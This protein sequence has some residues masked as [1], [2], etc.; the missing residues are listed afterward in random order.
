MALLTTDRTFRNQTLPNFRYDIF[1]PFSPRWSYIQTIKGAH[2]L[3]L[4]LVES[5]IMFFSI[6]NSFHISWQ[7]RATWRRIGETEWVNNVRDIKTWANF[8]LNTSP[9]SYRFCLGDIPFWLLSPGYVLSIHFR[10]NL[11]Y[12]AK[13][14]KWQ[15]IQKN[16]IKLIMFYLQIVFC[17][18]TPFLLRDI[19]VNT[20]WYCIDVSVIRNI[21]FC[22]FTRNIKYVT[23]FLLPKRGR[24]VSTGDRRTLGKMTL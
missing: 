21:M 19:Q 1:P 7:Y 3:R 10:T 5:M 13:G 15:I 12:L 9:H 23:C 14:S 20:S 8:I 17:A 11:P 6:N 16:Y 4:M 22:T 24:N 18:E 2:L